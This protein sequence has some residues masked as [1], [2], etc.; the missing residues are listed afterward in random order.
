M[1]FA[2]THTFVIEADSREQFEQRIADWRTKVNAASRRLDIGFAPG[3]VLGQ[4]QPELAV[5]SPPTTDEPE[6]LFDA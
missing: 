1:R 2:C 3:F 6:T 5:P 4:A